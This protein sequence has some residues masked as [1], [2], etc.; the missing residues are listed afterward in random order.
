[1][2]DLKTINCPI[3]L[4][5]HIIGTKWCALIIRDLLKGTKRFGELQRGLNNIS[6]KVLSDNLRKLEQENL[7]TRK[8][9]PEVPL[10][11]EY[12]LTDLGRSLEPIFDSL[13]TWGNDFKKTL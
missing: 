6:Q 7:I 12:S 9:Y 4:T 1:M 3:E 11:V 5:L 10:K 8:V 2:E 13:H